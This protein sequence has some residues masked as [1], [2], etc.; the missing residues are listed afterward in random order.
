MNAT[1]TRKLY[2]DLVIR[3]DGLNKIEAIAAEIA[4]LQADLRLEILNEIA[5]IEE[6]AP[7]SPTE[8]KQLARAL[9]DDL[10]LT[11]ADLTLD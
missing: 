6:E 10:A 4:R 2:A 1:R 11:G 3:V 9:W 8:R 7:F 5:L